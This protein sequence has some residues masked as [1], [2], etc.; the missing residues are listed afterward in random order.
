V[1]RAIVV[2]ALSLCLVAGSSAGAHAAPAT[3]SRPGVTH[4][5]DPTAGRGYPGDPVEEARLV[6]AEERR[7]I[8]IESSISTATATGIALTRP[9]RM[10]TTGVQTVVLVGRNSAYTLEELARIAPRS[11]VLQGDGSYLVSEHIYVAE[12]ATLRLKGDGLQVK[13]SSSSDGFASI[14]AVGGGLLI[15]GD[16]GAPIS[17]TSWDGDGADLNT[18]D[19]RAYVREHGGHASIVN[20]DFSNLGFWS[21]VT[22]GLSLTGTVIPEPLLADD[23]E[24]AATP[25]MP[26]EIAGIEGAEALGGDA[27]DTL[28]LD[29]ELT[30]DGYASAVIQ[31]VTVIGCAFGLFVTNSDRVDIRGSHFAENLV[32]GLVFHRDVTNTTVTGTSAIGN[33]Q[34]GFNLT[35]ATSDVVFDGLM[36]R[37]NG[38]NGITLEGR[39]LVDGP[40]ATG[41]S[42]A[43]YGDNEVRNSTSTDNGRYG[44]EVVGGRNITVANN[45][46]ARNDMGIVVDNGAVS[47]I[48]RG[49]DVADSANQGIALRDA[50]VD[51][52][53]T[54]NRIDGAEIGIFVRDAGG[55]FEGNVV[56]DA[57]NHGIALVGETGASTIVGNTISGAGPSAIDVYRTSGVAV[58]DNDVADWRS[59]KPITVVLR[60]VFQPLTILWLV[61]GL[62]ILASVMFARRLRGPRDPFADHAPLATFTRGIVSRDEVVATT[63]GL[64]QESERELLRER[65][66]VGAGS[67]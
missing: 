65:E 8:D 15:E 12:G 62:T 53:V 56:T 45:E 9:F 26:E 61:I 11:V 34:D 43:V 54:G 33:A 10:A 5:D 46:V 21:G 35:R 3:E 2:S 36:A 4:G 48:V 57:S 13:L 37:S 31:S 16:A 19:G 7:L 51:A 28:A 38:R 18:T 14:V 6:A 24:S 41:I 22:G 20:T 60:A 23:V 17:I 50:G 44:I 29:S 27:L 64:E 42:T 52:V 39:S 67:S 40:S 25:A 49:N 32:D 58:R 55:A 1:I 30:V 66:L 59:T 63:S 47:V